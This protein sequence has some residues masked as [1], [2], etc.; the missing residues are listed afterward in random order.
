MIPILYSFRRC[1]YA[2]RARLALAYC[3]IKCGLREISLKSKPE[4]MLV[5]SPKGTVPVLYLPRSKT[6]LEQSFDIMLWALEQN[7]TQ[8]W[9]TGDKVH[10]QSILDLI[11]QNDTQ[12]KPWL[13]KYKYASRFPEQDPLH[14][15]KNAGLYLKKIEKCLDDNQ[16]LGGEQ[17]NLADMATLP[18]VRQFASVD[19]ELF[20]KN[21][22]QLVYWLDTY[23]SSNI[24]E[25]VMHKY[26]IWDPEQTIIYFPE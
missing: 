24:F 21:H 11:E 13:D 5:L 9:L 22:P 19:R 2:M 14:Y 3:N 25:T 1:P 10:Q 4:E 6:V 26:P 20:D 16:Y 23:L 15:F 7:P 8:T 12:F 18:F 17:V